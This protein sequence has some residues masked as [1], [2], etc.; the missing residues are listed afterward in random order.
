MRMI[1]YILVIA[2]ML[3]IPV[4]RLDIAKLQPVEA[5]AVYEEQGCII[6]ETDEGSLGKGKTATE[7]LENLKVS[8]PAVVYL[9]TAD[10]LL[11][12][13]NT[14]EAARELLPYLKRTIQTGIYRG[15]DVKVEAKYFAV[16]TDNAKPQ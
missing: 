9:D 4:K 10:Y 16:H 13:E 1:L 14:Q 5:V 3:M 2:A 8:T 11:I 6:L 7:A 12:G 15:G